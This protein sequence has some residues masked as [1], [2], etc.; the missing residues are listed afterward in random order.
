MG[1]KHSTRLKTRASS[2]DPLV[3]LS[4]YVSLMAGLL[5][6]FWILFQFAYS[7]YVEPRLSPALVQV[8]VDSFLVGQLDCCNVHEIITRLE[9]KG[10][11]N[12]VLH[13]SHQVVGASRIV[14]TPDLSASGVL[15]VSDK[16]LRSRSLS[17]SDEYM[18]RSSAEYL[19]FPP[20]PPHLMISVG[21]LAHP[22]SHLAPGE[23]H[24]NRTIAL[25]P[26]DYQLITIRGV[27]FVSHFERSDLAWRWTITVDTLQPLPLAWPRNEAA[28][29]SRLSSCVASEETA[30]KR[31]ECRDRIDSHAKETFRK[32]WEQ[33]SNSYSQHYASDV[34][35]TPQVP[36]KK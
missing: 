35:A 36:P 26:K 19:A 1:P 13:A 33:D 29:L 14:L 24:I 7:N 22:G 17:G 23:T 8:T 31:Q 30:A 21:N 28:E 2:G 6:G 34:F 32:H 20:A 3:R 5:G 11:R 15:A 16:A 27:V 25:V 12:T 9:N 18:N 10:V 4:G